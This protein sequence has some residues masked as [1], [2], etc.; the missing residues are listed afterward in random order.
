MNYILRYETKSRYFG[1]K[2]VYYKEFDNTYDI[3]NFIVN[4]DMSCW[5]VYTPIDI[6]ISELLKED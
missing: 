3:F 4:N 2:K 5:K 6:S 1:F